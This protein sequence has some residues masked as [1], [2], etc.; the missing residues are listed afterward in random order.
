MKIATKNKTETKAKVND[1]TNGKFH[2]VDEPITHWLMKAEPDSRIV[3]GKDVKF[4]IDDLKEMGTSPW[5]GVRNHQAKNYMRDQMKVGQKVLF[6]H[7]N[8]KIPGVAGIA[9]IVKEGY[10]DDT[11]FDPSHPYYDPKSEK[12]KPTWYM[13][14]VKY[15]GHLNEFVSLKTAQTYEGPELKNMALI[16]RGRLSVQPV[17][18][19]EFDTIIRLGG[20]I[21]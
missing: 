1:D 19:E 18:K 5:D 17:T 3:K 9:E 2:T 13:V 8:T 6:Y 14:S 12:E 10:V 16:R 7:S 20:G 11:A 15:V 4:S 21:E